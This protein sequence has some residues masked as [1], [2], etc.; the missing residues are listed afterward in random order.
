M[1]TPA[2]LQ[3]STFNFQCNSTAEVQSEQS[4]FATLCD[5]AFKF[6]NGNEHAREPATFNLQPSTFNFQC[7]PTA[8]VQ[9]EQR[10]FA[11]LCDF[12]FKIQERK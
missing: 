6:K 8:E 11:T 2:N 3:L 1:S 5:F 9:R 4:N 12:A 10:Y 7:N